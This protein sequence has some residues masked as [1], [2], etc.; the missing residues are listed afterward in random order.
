M[1]DIQTDALITQS[2]THD[3]VPCRGNQVLR[4][5]CEMTVHRNVA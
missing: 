1:R 2:D 4:H 3:V 5:Y